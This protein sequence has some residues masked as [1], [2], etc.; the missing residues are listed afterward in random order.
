MIG[1]N[2]MV[3]NVDAI[4]SGLPIYDYTKSDTTGMTIDCCT[5]KELKILGIELNEQERHSLIVGFVKWQ[6]YRGFMPLYSL[7]QLLNR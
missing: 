3:K 6:G 2:G 7:K 4:A 5:I 1:R